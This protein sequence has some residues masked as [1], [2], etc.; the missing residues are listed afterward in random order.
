ME[1]KPG[2]HVTK[3]STTEWQP[4]PEVPGSRM[5]ELIHD[6]PVYAGLT[7]FDD[8]L[9]PISWTPGQREVFAVLEGSLR[10]E[11]DDGSD[12]TL[13]VGDIATIPAGMRTTWHLTTPYR[14]MWVLVES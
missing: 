2:M 13:E 9:E 14:E 1:I 12:I 6:G 8:P 4:D 11:F 7:R 10:I 5:H 3:S